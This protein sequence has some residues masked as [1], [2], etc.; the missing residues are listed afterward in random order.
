MAD[1]KTPIRNVPKMAVP[2]PGFPWRRLGSGVVAMVAAG[3]LVAAGRFYQTHAMPAVSL[4]GAPVAFMGYPELRNIAAEKASQLEIVFSA[5]GKTAR[6]DLGQIG[7]QIDQAATAKA[8]FEARRMGDMPGTLA[9]WQ[10]RNVPLQISINK[11]KLQQYITTTF[12]KTYAPP[13]EPDLR[14]SPASGQFELVPGQAGKGFDVEQIAL[15]ITRRA[16]NPGTIV[17]KNTAQSVEPAIGDDAAV[18]AQEQANQVVGLEMEFL[19][20]QKPIYFP[21]PP[22][23]AGWMEFVPDTNNGE[24][25]IRYDQAAM[26]R[27]LENELAASLNRFFGPGTNRPYSSEQPLAITEKDALVA[28]MV[29]AMRS[30]QTFSKEIEA[31]PAEESREPAL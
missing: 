18:V 20:K 26:K 15:N 30:L 16:E 2:G 10:T 5:G 21:E 31:V 27:F 11:Q 17:L 14:Y 12:P 1:N 6:P 23:I 29:H 25:S 8:A 9:L 24:L 7:I 28:D 3:G 13:Q 22:Q 4:A 19:Y